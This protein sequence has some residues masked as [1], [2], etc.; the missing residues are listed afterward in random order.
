MRTSGTGAYAAWRPTGML[1]GTPEHAEEAVLVVVEETP[2]V[3]LV[4][5]LDRFQLASRDGGEEVL[6]LRASRSWNAVVHAEETAAPEVA[7]GLADGANGQVVDE[8]HQGDVPVVIVAAND[9][10]VYL[11]LAIQSVRETPG[12]DVGRVR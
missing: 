6:D 4:L 7:D 1:A 3:E 8:L 12:D 5:E 9:R 11:A 2:A 10:G